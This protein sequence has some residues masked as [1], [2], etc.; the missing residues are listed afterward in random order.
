MSSAPS[1]TLVGLLGL[2]EIQ[3]PDLPGHGELVGAYSVITGEALGLSCEKVDCLLVAGTFHDIGKLFLEREILLEEG[4]LSS[5]QWAKVQ[6]HPQLGAHHLAD[7]GLE[8]I[9]SWVSAHH[10]RPD[11]TGYPLGLVDEEIPL[12]AKILA[13]ADSYDAMR[14]ERVYRAAMS[15][16]QAVEELRRN[17]GTQFDAEVVDALLSALSD[18]T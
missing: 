15:H 8:E 3:A 5:R 11:G 1:P 14:T 17:S 7:A 6:R 4:P 2:L 16:E 13:V 18:L 12:E 10:E 9:A